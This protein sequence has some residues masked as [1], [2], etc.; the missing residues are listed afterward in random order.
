M[1]SRQI[2]A[3]C[4][5]EQKYD[6]PDGGRWAEL[7]CG[8]VVIHEPPTTD[9]GTAVLNLSR[10]LAVWLEQ[11][12]DGYVCFEPGLI[13]SR[14]PDTVLCPS[15]GYFHE[16]DGWEEMD[17][18]VTTTRP[19]LIIEVA[20]TPDRRQAIPQ[21]LEL[22]RTAGC[23]LFWVIDPGSRQI[24]IHT[25]A[26]LVE[27]L[28]S[29]DTLTSRPAWTTPETTRPLLPGFSLPVDAVFQLPDWWTGV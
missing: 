10:A 11:T 29:G 6:L 17:K 22:Y 3:E 26:G 21:R 2:T 18:V 9:H 12:R 4:F 15:I 19:V 16:G 5:A 24:A 23:R 28:K 8:E 14:D 7:L 25:P 13:I 1:I 27:V 20:S